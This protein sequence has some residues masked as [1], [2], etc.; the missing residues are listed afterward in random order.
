MVDKP[1]PRSKIEKTILDTLE[2]SVKELFLTSAPDLLKLTNEKKPL[3]LCLVGINGA[4]ETT[5]IAKLAKMFLNNDKSVVIAAA[6]TFRA[7]AI[8]QLQI[9]AD[10]RCVKLIKHEDGADAAAVAFDAINHA[11][12][13]MATG[14]YSTKNASIAA[15]SQPFIHYVIIIFMFLAGT[16]FTLSYFALSGKF[17]KLIKNQE[18]KMYFGITVIVALVIAA[19]L[20]LWENS[21]T[22]K[23]FRDSLFQV[24]SITTTTGFATADYDLWFPLGRMLIILLFFGCS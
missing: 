9:H 5:T 17:K 10:N 13:T 4:G 1:L 22:E 2:R 24:V 15:F 8:D 16:N 11:F 23:A 7:A 3:V 21:P 18:F 12:T 19:G 6:D 20:I 14:G